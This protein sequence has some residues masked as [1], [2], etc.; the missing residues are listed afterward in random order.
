MAMLRLPALNRLNLC[1]G[2]YYLIIAFSDLL[3]PRSNN[4][5]AGLC[6]QARCRR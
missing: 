4:H 1:V 6:E 5:L 2:A 3:I